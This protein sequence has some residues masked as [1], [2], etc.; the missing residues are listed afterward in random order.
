MLTNLF[1]CVSQQLTMHLHFHI[2]I[3]TQLHNSYVQVHSNYIHEH[4]LMDLQH[5]YYI[6]IDNIV[7]EYY[8]IHHCINSIHEI[9]RCL[10]NG[11][12]IVS[13]IV[14][15][16]QTWWSSLYAITINSCKYT[17][18]QLYTT[19]SFLILSLNQLAISSNLAIMILSIAQ[20]S[21]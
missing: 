13:Y 7:I 2:H 9:G 4:Q 16:E 10:S 6:T 15:N 14:F 3:T 18:R 21:S 19:R 5:Q 11:C 1:T 8:L 12:K 17:R 20:I